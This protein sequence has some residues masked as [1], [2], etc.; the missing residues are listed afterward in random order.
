MKFSYF[1][2]LVFLLVVSF[3]F[4]T[5]CEKGQEELPAEAMQGIALG[6]MI[7]EEEYWEGN[8]LEYNDLFFVNE[9]DLFTR[10]DSNK[11]YSGIIKVRSRKGTIS[12]LQSY[13]AGLKDG[14]FFEYHENGKLKSK[15]QYKMGMRHGYH[16]EWLTDGTIYSRKYYQDDLEDFGRFADEGIS[17]T[18]K[19]MAALELAKWEG[20]AEDFYFKFAGDP[21]RGGLVHIRETEE[22]Y[23]GN[24]TALDNQGRKEAMLRFRKGKYHGTISKWDEKG[25]LWEEAE[26][27]RGILVAFTIKHGKPFDPTQ[28]ID[29][30]EDPDMVKMLFGD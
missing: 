7:A 13:S 11:T 5:G 6:D 30:S 3:S 29:V 26:Y 1:P 4:F 20:K 24:V 10:K 22:L 18:G 9:K 17:T 16:Y 2:S 21:K 25:S 27:D 28:V 12:L 23:D 14:D 15:R 19:S 8:K